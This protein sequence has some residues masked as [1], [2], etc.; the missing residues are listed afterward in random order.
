MVRTSGLQTNSPVDCFGF[1]V[2]GRGFGMNS[3]LSTEFGASGALYN[4]HNND[5]CDILSDLP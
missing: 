2:S 4:Y 5:V 3:D 1:V